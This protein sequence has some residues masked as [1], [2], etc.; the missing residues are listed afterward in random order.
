MNSPTPAPGSLAAA[1]AQ[2][3]DPRR[4]HLRVHGLVPLLPM[5][6]AVYARRAGAV[7]AQIRARE[8]GAELPATQE[9]L[10]QV[11]LA[12]H[13]VLG[14]ALQTQREVCEPIGDREGEYLFP[15]KENQPALRADL[16]EAFSPLAPAERPMGSAPRI[17]EWMQADWRRRGVTPTTAYPACTKVRH[18]RSERREMWVLWDPEWA[19]DVGSAGK[20]GQPWPPLQQLCRVRRERTVKGQTTVEVGYSIPSLEPK[21]AGAQ[22]LLGLSREYWEIE[23]RLHWVRDVTLEEDRSQVRSGAAPQVCAG[24]RNLVIGLL[25][26]VGA[27]KIA[28]ALRT[29]SARPRAAVA[30][31]LS[32]LLE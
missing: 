17:P 19:A 16:G 15:V 7:L 23:N 10:A 31:V 8:K 32:P 13:V 3:P 14:D 5:A 1:L 2:I 12:G 26:R 24:L 20:V 4:P 11:D 9:A 6:V 29:Y 27:P 21:E 28:A 25:R 18:G 22:R 30:L